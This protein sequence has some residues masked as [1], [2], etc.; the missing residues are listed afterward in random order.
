MMNLLYIVLIV[1]PL[2]FYGVLNCYFIEGV[3]KYKFKNS[4]A[5][6]GITTLLSLI[7]GVLVATLSVDV[8]TNGVVVGVDNPVVLAATVLMYITVVSLLQVKGW[9]RFAVAF[10]AFD[11]MSELNVIFVDTREMLF[12]SGS[13]S[14]NPAVMALLKFS[15][16]FLI[17]LEFFFL[18]ALDRLRRK[19][20]SGP[21]P[22]PIITA[23][24]MFLGIITS[25]ISVF[26]TDD[27]G[28]YYT[29]NVRRLVTLFILTIGLFLVFLFFYLRV[30]R[31]ERD[32]LR[33]LNTSNEELVESQAKY[34]EATVDADNKIRAM[35][36]DMR[37]NLQ[38]LTLLLESGEY[39]KMREY[40]E[41][42]GA[43]LESA[44]ISAH[45][46]DMIAD[47]IIAEKMRKASESGITL[48]VSGKISGV[49]FAPVDMCKILGN[50]LDNAIEAASDE[51]L[52]GLDEEHRCIDLDFKKTDN[53]FMIS[54][55][56]PCA[57]C[58][59]IRDGTIETVKSD[60][61]NHGFGLKNIREAAVKYN[62]E[63]SMECDEMNT[64]FLFRT[65]ILFNLQD[66]S[67]DLT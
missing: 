51:R 8:K 65:E 27:D 54:M 46:G 19:S 22:L 25:L 11:I 13:W 5:A 34:F 2:L 3:L 62:G 10:L 57:V 9:R 50:M 39:D 31:K 17:V 30:T 55:S 58:P 41:Q 6:Y 63:L 21:L 44:D 56:N 60:K 37:N 66:E 40:L 4:K 35:R 53:F 42:M 43:N 36:H 32:D 28:F 48:K 14:S 47:A 23:V 15:E 33:V 49:E 16:F 26:A 29:D 24:W 1:L 67:V 52:E 61:K 38:V 64:G 20:D 7:M 45:T 18:V 59:V 12:V